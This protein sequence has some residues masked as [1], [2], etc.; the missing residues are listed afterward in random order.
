MPF[1]SAEMV[2]HCSECD[3]DMKCSVSDAELFQKE[4]YGSVTSHMSI[5][6]ESCETELELI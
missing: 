1:A 5:R 3:H 6:C 4:Y 2:V